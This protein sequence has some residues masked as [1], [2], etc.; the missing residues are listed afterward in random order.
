MQSHVCSVSSL[1]SHHTCSL[2]ECLS[3]CTQGYVLGREFVCGSRVGGSVGVTNIV[4]MQVSLLKSTQHEKAMSDVKTTHS[5]RIVLRIP[6]L[7]LTQLPLQSSV[8]TPSRFRADQC[9]LCYRQECCSLSAPTPPLLFF[10][11]FSDS[12]K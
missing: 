3:S 9:F 5:Q 2:T 1:C 7:L 6:H 11:L 12:E 8:A 4:F 10:F